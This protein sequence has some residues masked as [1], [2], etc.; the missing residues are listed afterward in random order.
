MGIGHPDK[1]DIRPV[2]EV[3]V[4]FYPSSQVAPVEVEVVDQQGALGVAD[5]HD[6][7]I[8]RAIIQRQGVETDRGFRL[9]HVHFKAKTRSAAL[10]QAKVFGSGSRSDYYISITSKALIHKKCGRAASAISRKFG[11]A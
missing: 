4:L 8:A 6:N 2:R 10:E 7:H 11:F 3:R 9:A 1:R 5:I